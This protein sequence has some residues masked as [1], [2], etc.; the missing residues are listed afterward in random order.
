MKYFLYILLVIATI[1]TGFNVSQIDFNAPFSEESKVAFIAIL[2]A[3]CVIILVSIL[4]ISK[5]IE[6]KYKE[7]KQ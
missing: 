7:N 4:L 3:L 2:A 1:M 5:A 6:R